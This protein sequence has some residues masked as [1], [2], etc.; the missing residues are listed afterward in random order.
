MSDLYTEDLFLLSSLKKDDKNAFDRLFRKYYPAL[1]AYASRY[2]KL[3]DAKEIAQDIMVWLWETRETCPV[4]NSLSQYL[5]KAAYRRA[6]DYHARKQLKQ[7]ADTYFYEE[8]TAILQESDFYQFEELV[9]RIGRAIED[10]PPAYRDA[11]VMHR[12]HEMSYKDIA[13][14]LHVSPKTIDYRIQQ[15]LKILRKELK[16][17]LPWLTLFFSNLS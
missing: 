16:D 2:V 14:K 7:R 17:Y 13:V 4:A 11:F 9:K 5:F 8:M 15:A 3:E 1:C 12:F 6:L 10:L